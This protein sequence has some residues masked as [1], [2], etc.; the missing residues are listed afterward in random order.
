M[1]K[2]FACLKKNTHKSFWHDNLKS[3]CENLSLKY[4]V[5]DMG[6]AYTQSRSIVDDT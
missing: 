3:Y 2:K 6:H 4:Y 5:M 1:N